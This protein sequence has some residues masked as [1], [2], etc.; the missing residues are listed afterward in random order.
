MPAPILAKIEK[1]AAAARDPQAAQALAASEP[2]LQELL[3][4]PSLQSMLKGEHLDQALK[5]G[6]ISALKND[7]KISA[8]L[9]DPRIAGELSGALGGASQNGDTANR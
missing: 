8:L 7:P 2:K 5:S 9:N 6:D 3:N 1:L 4:D